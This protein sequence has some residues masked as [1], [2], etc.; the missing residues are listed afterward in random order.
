MEKNPKEMERI[1]DI[2]KLMLK[3]KVISLKGELKRDKAQI[4]Y[5]KGFIEGLCYK[6]KIT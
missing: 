6:K 5:L 3:V 4:A 1:N 2:E